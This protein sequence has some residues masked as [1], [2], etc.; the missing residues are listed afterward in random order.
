MKR[1]VFGEIGDQTTN[2]NLTKTQIR[3]HVEP[4]NLIW[5][6]LEL[7]HKDGFGGNRKTIVPSLRQYQNLRKVL[8]HCFYEDQYVLEKK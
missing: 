3:P 6:V 8:V 2:I 7:A 5:K 4:N 1:A